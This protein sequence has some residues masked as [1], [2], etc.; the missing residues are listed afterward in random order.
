MN[1]SLTDITSITYSYKIGETVKY[2]TGSFTIPKNT[3]VNTQI[4][5]TALTTVSDNYAFGI[6]TTTI[7]VVAEDD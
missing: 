1:E 3:P 6:E 2:F 7:T 5:L 4:T